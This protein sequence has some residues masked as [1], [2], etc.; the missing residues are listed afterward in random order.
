[1][2]KPDKERTNWTQARE[3]KKKTNERKTKTKAK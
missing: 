1:M 2:I 3:K